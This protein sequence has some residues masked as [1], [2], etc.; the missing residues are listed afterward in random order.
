MFFENG[1]G[2]SVQF[3]PGN[4]CDRRGSS[5]LS[6]EHQGLWDSATAEVAIF[7]SPNWEFLAIGGSG[8][9][10]MGDLKPILVGKIIAIISSL[11]A[12]ADKESTT[13]R[14]KGLLQLESYR[15]PAM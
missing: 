7:C 4:Y 11:P 2:I 15:K 10:V 14:V 1:W 8:D 3:G 6:V 12:D 9:P 5:Y 13:H